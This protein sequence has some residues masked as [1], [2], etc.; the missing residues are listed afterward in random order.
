LKFKVDFD[1][2]ESYYNDLENENWKVRKKAVLAL[3]KI[4]DDRAIDAL[5]KTLGMKNGKFVMNLYMF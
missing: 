4:G 5:I 2:V 3:G 1:N